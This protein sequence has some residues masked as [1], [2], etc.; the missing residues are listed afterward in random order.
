MN[1]IQKLD[2][3][4]AAFASRLRRL[5]LLK[6][7]AATAG[8]L[9]LVSVI[10]AWFSMQSGF[11][12]SVTNIFR[13]VLLVALAAVVVLLIAKPLRRL[14]NHLSG[15]VVARVPAVNGRIDNYE[16]M[17]A[18]DNPFLELLAEDTL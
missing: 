5:A 18:G 3:Y 4:L 6:G 17:K 8:V 16:Q 12:A 1:A 7:A 10:G 9:L 11:A 13:R 15:F 14:R 2:H